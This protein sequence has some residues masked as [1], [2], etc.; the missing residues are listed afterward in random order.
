MSVNSTVLPIGDKQ[1]YLILDLLRGFA[2]LG[3]CMANFPEFSLY[4]FLDSSAT[5]SMPTAGI[6]YFVNYFLCIFVDG[7]FYTIFSLLFGI[8]FSIIISNVAERG[9]NGLAVFYRRMFYLLIIGF[10]HLMFVWSGDIL[11]LY[12]IVGMLLP[13]FIKSSDKVILITAAIFLFLPVLVDFTCQWT[14]IYLSKAIV[15]WQGIYCDRYGITSENFAYWLR[16]AQ[17]YDDVFKFLIQGAIV[18]LQEFVDGNRYFKVLGLF[19]IGFYIGRNRLYAKFHDYFNILKKILLS[20][21]FIGFPLSWLYAFSCMEGR[22]WGIGVHSLLYFTSVYLTS[23]GYIAAI[24][25]LFLKYKNLSLWKALSF[26]GRMALT[27]YIGQSVAGMIIFYGIGL[28]LGADMGLVF[29]EL[30]VMCV[31]SCEVLFSALRLKF[32]RFGP[33]E[34]IWRCLTY[35]KL[36]SLYKT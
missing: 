24:C 4:T 35:N 28:G 3:I 33:L 15:E 27:N 10:I 5:G 25:L 32:F 26:P 17:S 30:I 11:M 31:Y 12:A 20:G 2:L 16:D 6:D 22:P 23:F 7:K 36:F 18:R 29:V 1:R 19:L 13:L 9:G 34:W 8:G 21:L 14:G